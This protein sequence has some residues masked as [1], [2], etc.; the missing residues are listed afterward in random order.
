MATKETAMEEWTHELS[1]EDKIKAFIMLGK[2]RISIIIDSSSL[3]E[4]TSLKRI[5][6]EKFQILGSCE[7]LLLYYFPKH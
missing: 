3:A 2:V 1:K 6:S 7:P 4:P 5:V